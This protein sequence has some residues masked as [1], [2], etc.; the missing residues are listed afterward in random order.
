MNKFLFSKILP[1]CLITLSLLN[2]GCAT[3][4]GRTNYAVSINSN[5]VSSVTITD[6]KGL[7][8]YKGATPATVNLPSSA[9]YFL[10]GDISDKIS[11]GW[12]PG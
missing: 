6:R 5:P 3:I 2:S 12:L 1:I 7:E 10:R 8:I 9:G 4:F 11:P